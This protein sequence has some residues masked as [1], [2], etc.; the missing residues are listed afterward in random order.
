MGTGQK[1]GTVVNGKKHRQLFKRLKSINK[2][3]ELLPELTPRG[4]ARNSDHYPFSQKN[5]PSFF[6]YLRGS[7]GHYH[8]IYDQSSTLPLA[9][10]EELFSLLTRFSDQLQ[11]AP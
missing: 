1:G 3:Q 5:V 4:T 8:D 6:I 11:K 9:T 2:K 10:Y 7:P